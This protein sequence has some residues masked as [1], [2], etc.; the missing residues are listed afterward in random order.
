MD[1]PIPQH[2]PRRRPKTIEGPVAKHL[3]MQDAHEAANNQA[4]KNEAANKE[5]ASARHGVDRNEA[6]A[7][8]AVAAGMR[9]LVAGRLPAAYAEFKRALDLDPTSRQA[10][11]WRLVCEARVAKSEGHADAARRKYEAVLELDPGH[12]EALAATAQEQVEAPSKGGRLGRWFGR[13]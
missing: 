9:H 10:E 8:L 7:E 6:D 2:I 13:D 3:R 12:R 4:A 1:G 5:W 11:L